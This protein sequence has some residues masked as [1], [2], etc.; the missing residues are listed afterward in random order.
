MTPQK[1]HNDVL[2]ECAN[3]E[4]N[5]MPENQWKKDEHR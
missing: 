3:E 5:E 2:L 4:I 1:E